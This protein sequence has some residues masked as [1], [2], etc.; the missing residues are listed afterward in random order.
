VSLVF[1]CWI[2][3][4]LLVPLAFGLV[5]SLVLYPLVKWLESKGLNLVWS[6]L[7][8]MLGIFLLSS[9]VLFF[10][11]AKLVSIIEEYENFQSKLTI[12]VENTISFMNESIPFIS[13]VSPE[14]LMD[15]ISSFFA[16]SG[17]FI[18][19][20]TITTTGTTL[21]YILLATLYTFLIL[22]YHK[23]FTQ[24]AT[25][26]VSEENREELLN[27][28][29]SVQK[30][31]QQ[32]LTGMALLILILGVLNSIGLLII[33]LDYAIFFGFLAAI[34]AI[35]PYVGTTLGG[36]IPALYALMTMDS[37]W[38]AVA[39]VLTFWF[40]QTLEGNVLSPKIVGGNLNLNPLAAVLALIAGGLLWGLPGM[41][42]ALPT[43]A[44][45]KVIFEHYKQLQ[46]VALFLENKK[47]DEEEGLL[48]KIV[49][50][51][52]KSN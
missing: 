4:T 32:Y 39:V 34:L 41:I 15:S 16:D 38:Y 6:I 17:L 19:S 14:S 35:I 8:T 44:I 27:M 30:V 18:V 43:V 22:L 31:G 37:Y 21:S 28:L 51:V 11:S 7:F 42:L 2:A 29:R 33:G 9:G 36:F 24:A 47:T 1:V 49:K 12:L 3:K 25:A 5:F 52:R 20:D 45:L 26:F 40:I 10:F 46:P 48:K 13:G 50:K 23:N